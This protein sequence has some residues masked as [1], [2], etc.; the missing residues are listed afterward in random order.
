MILNMKDLQ[1]IERKHVKLA[2][3]CI[4]K[5]GEQD[6][7]GVW[8]LKVDKS[9]IL[10]V[11]A[12]E[13]KQEYAQMQVGRLAHVYASGETTEP[14]P[15]PQA[16]ARRGSNRVKTMCKF[17]GRKFPE[18]PIYHR[19]EQTSI[20]TNAPTKEDSMTDSIIDK[21]YGLLRQFYQIIFY[22]PPGTGKTRAAKLLLPS[23]LGVDKS[24]VES[25]RGHR[26]DIVQ[27]HPSYNYEDFVRGIQAEAVGDKVAYKMVNRIFGDMCHKANAAPKGEKYALII[28]EI[29]R[30]NVSAVLGELIYA[31]EYRGQ[32]VNTPYAVK[33]E[34]K[35]EVESDPT[36]TIPKNLYVI[37]TMNTADRTI[38]QIDY[39]V[40]RRFAFMHCKPKK[41]MI[42][43]KVAQ[44]FFALVD[45]L[46]VKDDKKTPSDFIS[47]DFDAA[48]VRI[49]HSYF[50][51][52]ESKLGY[53][54][55]YQVVPILREY[56]KDGVLKESVTPKI[57]QIEEK[58]NE[59]LLAGKPPAGESAKPDSSVDKKNEKGAK[60]YWRN[61]DHFGV[62][63]VRH[64]AFGIIKDFIEKNPSMNLAA[65]QKEFKPAADGAHERVKLWENV[66][67]GAKYPRY[68]QDRIRLENSGEVVAISNRWGAAGNS[69]PPWN[70]FKK[71][72][73]SLGYSI[74]QYH[75]VN[76]GESDTRSLADSRKFGFVSARGKSHET[77]IREKVKKGDFLFIN[78]AENGPGGYVG[79]GE[80]LEA[81]V[82]I[83]NFK[84]DNEKFLADCD[85]GDG[86]TYQEK[87]PSAFDKKRPEWVL[88]V[89]WMPKDLSK[90][91][92]QGLQDAPGQF[93]RSVIRQSTFSELCKAFNIG[94]EEKD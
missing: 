34:D 57:D 88:R 75:L 70:A 5:Y 90:S 33:L 68:F 1:K 42:T 18:F 38:G 15:F 89:K 20:S 45:A 69:A 71:K 9:P 63:G 91:P 41:S 58:A 50:L 87:Y 48:D 93:Y 85:V 27:F 16:Y 74:G 40:R 11:I 84:P 43:D 73:A 22:G 52:A 6:S 7:D 78:W 46:F 53:R 2:F 30:A 13:N 3:D 72:V 54:L 56:V 39:A 49:G 61:G 21:A 28:D 81:A 94:N 47:P 67:W 24:K 92:L 26:W 65:L 86:T 37:G 31:L 44:N 10:L 76:L 29:N 62:G 23:L 82:R 80:V 79:C 83:E 55:V 36:L 77:Q 8:R 14:P 17:F 51:E 59:L 12:D 32:P 60:F 66:D 64:T 19:Q 35:Q 25:L 4:G